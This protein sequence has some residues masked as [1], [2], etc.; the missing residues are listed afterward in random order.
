M[1]F[2]NLSQL[3]ALGQ[4]ECGP[5]PGL[6]PG[7]EKVCCPELGWVVYDSSESPYGICE[8]AAAQVAGDAAQGAGPP[9]S[10]PLERVRRLRSELEEKRQQREEEAHQQRLQELQLRFVLGRMQSIQERAQAKVR[11]KEAAEAARIKAA[12]EA[13]RREQAKKV[14]GWGAAALAAAKLFSLF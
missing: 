8:R 11:A 14:L 4:S 5:A 9:T 13:K 2:L 6:G 7:E 1:S 3:G 12:A 10:D